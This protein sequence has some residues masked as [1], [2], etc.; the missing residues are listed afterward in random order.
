MQYNI[1]VHV[2]HPYT[3]LKYLILMLFTGLCFV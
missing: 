1:H 3:V 2:V